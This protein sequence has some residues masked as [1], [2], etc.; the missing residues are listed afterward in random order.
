M[1]KVMSEMNKR[2][3]RG[4]TLIE[5]LIVIAIIGIL[6]AIAVPAFLGQREKAKVRSVEAGAKGAVSDLQGYLDSYVAGDPYIIVTSTAGGQGCVEATNATATG[7]TCQAMYNQASTST[8]T[9]F[10][11]GIT[12]ILNDFVNHHTYKG[13]KSAFTGGSL[14]VT[15]HTTEGEIFVTPSGARAVNITAYATDTTSPIFSQ[16]VTTR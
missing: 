8:Y 9:A 1:F 4:F 16:V 15:T 14:F 3:E 11:G 5:L 2:D 7:K 10:P 13:D 12:D 6:T